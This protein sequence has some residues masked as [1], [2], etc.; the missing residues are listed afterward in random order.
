MMVRQQFGLVFLGHFYQFFDCLN[1]RA[2]PLF[3][4]YMGFGLCKLFQQWYVSML[5]CAN[6]SHFSLIRTANEFLDGGLERRIAELSDLKP[7]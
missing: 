1:C 3:T 5:L 6:D 7:A 4:Q 2:D